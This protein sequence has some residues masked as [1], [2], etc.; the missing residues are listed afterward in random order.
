METIYY[1]IDACHP[2]PE[3]I[4]RAA[5]A[6]KKGEIVVFPTETVYGVGAV[7]DNPEAVKK[8]F[9]A[10]KR[11]ADSPL[12]VH[13]SSREQAF[14]VAD[15]VPPLALKLMEAFWPGPLSLILP[16]KKGVPLEVTGGKDSVGLRMPDHPVARALID[17]A[18][19]LAATS[20]NLSGRPS[21]VRAEHVRQDLDG[22]VALVLDAGETGVGIESTII[23]M[24]GGKIKVLRLG[25]VALEDIARVAGYEIE[26]FLGDKKQ[27]YALKTKVL[28][29]QDEDDFK[30]LIN[31]EDIKLAPKGIVFYDEEEHEIEGI[32]EKYRLDL[33]KSSTAFFALL[34]E[35]ESKGI[36]FLIFYPLPS[37]AEGL[38]LSLIDRIYKAAGN[39]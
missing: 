34:R 36:E 6:L 5:E 26:G 27:H 30:S 23:D 11:P 9:A 39:K 3:I 14:L 24:T 18:G 2:E 17:A 20:A 38:N 28:L 29:A 8:V 35:A 37:A 25:G 4:F 7:Y 13:V 12:L 16:V 31:R 19:P 21:P 32:Y 10:K 1:K 22:R 15:Q 33:K